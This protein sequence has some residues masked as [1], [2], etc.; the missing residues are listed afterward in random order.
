LLAA[1]K[2]AAASRK[3]A[4]Q[5]PDRPTRRISI[6]QMRST[7]QRAAGFG[8]T[9]R[10]QVLVQVAAEIEIII[11]CVPWFH[12]PRPLLQGTYVSLQS[13]EEGRH[14]AHLPLAHHGPAAGSQ[15][16][17]EEGRAA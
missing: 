17:K 9:G 3:D 15:R 8:G 2:Q 5:L 16:K 11:I 6:D 7:W 10:L 1:K 12:H 4:S 13:Y 14:E